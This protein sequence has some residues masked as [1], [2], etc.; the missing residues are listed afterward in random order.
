M[1]PDA[2]NIPRWYVLCD[3]QR[4]WANGRWNVGGTLS[5]FDPSSLTEAEM[6]KLRRSLLQH[7]GWTG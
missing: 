6:Y 2:Q 5:Q 1:I 3:K 4:W 7:F